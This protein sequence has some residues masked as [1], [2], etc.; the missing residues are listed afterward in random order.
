M[1]TDEAIRHL[2]H[3]KAVKQIK[4]HVAKFNPM[5]KS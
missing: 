5:Q 2:F 1:T 3:P 4:K